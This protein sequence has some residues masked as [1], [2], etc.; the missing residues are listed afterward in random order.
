MKYLN[1]YVMILLLLIS[2]GCDNSLNALDEEE[3]LYSIYGYL[4]LYEDNNYIRI[5]DIN[6]T[7]KDSDGILDAKVTFENLDNGTTEV[8]QDTVVDFDGVKTHNFRTTIDINPDTEYRVTA[9]R[10]DGRTT[11]AIA[12]TPFIA[13]TNVNP[14]GA[15]CITAVNIDFEPVR[16]KNSLWVEVGFQYNQN[17]FWV[18]INTL[19]VE[20]DN[21]VNA[22]FTPFMLINEAFDERILCEDLSDDTFEVR[23]THYGPDL[24]ENT[25]SDTLDVPGGA[26]RFG[27]FYKDSFSFPID[28][29]SLCP[30]LC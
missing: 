15:N 1:N 6:Q 24:F 2:S 7:L 27:A 12:K 5:K 28:T 29:V 19:L 30:P 9:K 3:G 18:R 16:S 26:G 10:S 8:L 21:T 23:Y 25:I 11:S 20:T 17:L 14:M 13:E 4:N 22:S